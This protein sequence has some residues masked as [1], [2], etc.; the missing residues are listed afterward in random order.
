MIFFS[1]AKA[2]FLAIL[3]GSLAV[4]Q[5]IATYQLSSGGLR[6]EMGKLIHDMM[7]GDVD[8][9]NLSPEAVYTL[10]RISKGT[11][12]FPMIEALGRIKAICPTV[13]LRYKKGREIS[14]RVEHE[15]GTLDWNIVISDDPEMLLNLV[16]FPVT[17]G[18]PAVLPYVRPGSDILPPTDF[19]CG[20]IIS[21]QASQ[22]ELARA[23]NK[24]PEMC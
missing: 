22:D 7:S 14:L 4:T 5:A 3:V 24:W 15:N 10:R 12:R 9:D 19:G 11:M 8:T 16:F 20:P 13:V 18:P 6:A 2:P 17:G 21:T 1:R 23:C